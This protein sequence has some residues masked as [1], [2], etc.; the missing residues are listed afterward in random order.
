MSCLD[1]L[2]VAGPCALNILFAAGKEQLNAHVRMNGC[3][4]RGT[5]HK[6]PLPV[7]SAFY[8]PAGSVEVG[9]DDMAETLLAQI[10]RLYALVSNLQICSLV[11]SWLLAVAFIFLQLRP[12]AAR[13]R[14][15]THRIARMLS[16]LPADVDVEGMVTRMLLRDGDGRGSGRHGSGTGM[17]GRGGGEAS[18]GGVGKSQVLAH[19][20]SGGY[21]L[22]LA[23]VNA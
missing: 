2:P 14:T 8:P 20:A 16:E 13:N 7:S 12:F 10:R 17:T 22:L 21:T 6:R 11:L 19:A 1:V 18:N 5:P 3:W 4:Y 9:M 23:R 15:E